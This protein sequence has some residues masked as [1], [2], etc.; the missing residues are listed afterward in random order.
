M[1]PGSRPGDT[2]PIPLAMRDTGYPDLRRARLAQA[3]LIGIAFFT[4][5][6][7]YLIS[8]LV[9]P[10]KTDL[11]LNDVEVGLAN[12]STLYGAYA[13]FCV[14]M[15]L[16]VDR[17]NRVRMLTVAM[18]VWCA[19]LLVNGLS[20]S[21]AMLV[22]SKV[23]LGLANAIT[24][25]AALS[26]LADYFPP[27]RRAM[28]TTSY[29]IGQGVGQAGAILIGGLGLGA[30]V[31]L[32]AARP[33]LLA[34]MA[35]WRLLSLAFAAAGALLVPAVLSLRE[36]R[37][38]EV[39]QASGGSMRELWAW[40]RF[41]VPLLAG[42][43]C[44]SALSSAILSWLAP[45]L[46]RLYGQQPGD[47]A[48]WFGAVSL[49]SVL[50]GMLAAGKLGEAA[51]KRAGRGQVMLPAVYASLLCAPASFLAMAP[52]LSWFAAG[53]VIFTAAYA[54]AITLPIIAIGLNIPNELR[55]AALGLYI[56]TVSVAAAAAA[57]L[58]AL[59]SQALGGEAMLGRG[60][61]LIGAP[62]ALL[63]ATS[64]WWMSRRMAQDDVREKTA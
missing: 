38:M 17:S 47:F 48:S 3:V 10:I 43:T 28:A 34:N 45:A 5:M 53:V 57:P 60:M 30:L 58:V 50:A 37:R 18:G 40:R 49:V 2:G 54:V 61:A 11:G 14:P 25:P 6:D 64:F 4:A 55:G 24:L 19:G 27:H 42:T 15:G 51:H 32:T 21:V 62:S 22:A 36:P 44:L 31:K 1:F 46:T 63:A 8:L 12:I 39:Q 16:L 33:D 23:L 59:A 20:T 29:G 56:V 35:P 13:L 9:E 41:L 7:I 52:S 26:L